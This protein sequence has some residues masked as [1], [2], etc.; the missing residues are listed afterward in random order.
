MTIDFRL[1]TYMTIMTNM[2]L[3]FSPFLNKHFD[4]LPLI[5]RR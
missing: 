5:C 4:F 3:T 2:T 1:L